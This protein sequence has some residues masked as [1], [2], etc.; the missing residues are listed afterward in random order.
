MAPVI[1]RQ[2]RLEVSEDA[3]LDRWWDALAI[4][5]F[6]PVEFRLVSRADDRILAQA[7]DLGHGLHRVRRRPRL[8]RL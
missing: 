5:P 1:R 6:R 8:D 7:I 4:G 3:M 2:T